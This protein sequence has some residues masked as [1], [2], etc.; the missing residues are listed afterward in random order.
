MF[1]HSLD[2]PVINITAHDGDGTQPNNLT[3]FE[4]DF[5]STGTFLIGRD[6]GHVTTRAELDRERQ[7]IYNITVT[8]K[9]RAVESKSCTCTFIVVVKDVNDELP[10]FKK[11]CAW[12][13][14]MLTLTV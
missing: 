5:E 9:D 4:L 11:V 8:V 14:L 2:R 6:T 12:C 13:N 7:D 3:S 10:Q 1:S